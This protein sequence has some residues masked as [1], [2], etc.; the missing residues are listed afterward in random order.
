M[1][2]EISSILNAFITNVENNYDDVRLAVILFDSPQKAAV[3]SSS[4]TKELCLAILNNDQQFKNISSLIKRYKK[5]ALI[6]QDLH[7]YAHSRGYSTLVKKNQVKSFW[8]ASLDDTK[9]G[10]KGLLCV[11]TKEDT[12]VL[13]EGHK[14]NLKLIRDLMDVTLVGY[15]TQANQMQYS[16]SLQ[17]LPNEYAQILSK[18]DLW[19]EMGFGIM[20]LNDQ[21]GIIEINDSAESIIGQ[22]KDELLGSEPFGEHW[23]VIY[24]DGSKMLSHDT[25]VNMALRTQKPIKGIHL[26]IYNANRN[27][28]LWLNIS[29]FPVREAAQKGN[30][31]ITILEEISDLVETKHQ[32]IE[33]QSVEK[34]RKQYLAKLSHEIRTPVNSILGMAS[35]LEKTDLTN[36]QQDYVNAILNASDHLLVLINDILNVSKHD[37]DSFSTIEEPFNLRELLQAIQQMLWAEIEDKN[38]QIYVSVDEKVPGNL[39][40]DKSRLKQILLNITSNAVK[41]TVEGEVRIHV[42]E[43]GRKN[44]RSSLKITIQD[45]GIGIP[46]EELDEIFSPFFRGAVNTDT[47]IEGVGL[48]LPIA[49]QLVALLGGTMELKSEVNIGTVCTLSIDIPIA[50]DSLPQ[51]W[52]ELNKL[53]LNLL[54]GK[55]VLVVDDN[56]AN[57]LWVDKLLET[58]GMEVMT[59]QNGFQAL[60]ILQH[61]TCDIILMDIHMPDLDGFKTTQ[62]IRSK[63]QP[64]INKIPIIGLTADLSDQQVIRCHEAGMKDVIGKPFQHDHLLVK[65]IA[66]LGGESQYHIEGSQPQEF[67]LSILEEMTQSHSQVIND[68]IRAFLPVLDEVISELPKKVETRNEEAVRSLLHKAIPTFKYFQI[69]A[70][71]ELK[72]LQYVLNKEGIH[73]LSKDRVENVIQRII[74]I[75]HLLN[76]HINNKPEQPN[77]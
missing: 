12:A 15:S 8:A 57:L 65:L 43:V 17:Q 5:N 77:E 56:Q 60:D 35:L 73:A 38:V 70:N 24:E 59:A 63:L 48:G 14:R 51:S 53:D 69:R 41:Y 37:R 7:Q 18:N 20:I 52:P 11:F 42:E 34:Q 31:F 2:S 16:S 49:K 46:E 44:N 62:K 4:L 26:G 36:N 40:G 64:S 74:N 23:K 39:L 47:N 55:Q 72:K 54:S 13:Q 21:G 76:K 22:P 75:R 10:I 6:I 19:D 27:A 45:T 68:F 30:S 66:N 1:V 3:I 9:H 25:P 67:D 71:R 33:S 50:D 32:M 61:Q 29:V 28:Y 58:Y